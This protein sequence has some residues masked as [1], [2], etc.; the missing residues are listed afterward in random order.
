MS[1]CRLPSM[2]RLGPFSTS[3]GLSAGRRRA[4]LA[5]NSCLPVLESAGR[6]SMVTW[7]HKAG[8]AGLPQPLGV[9]KETVRQGIEGALFFGG[10]RLAKPALIG[11]CQRHDARMYGAAAR[12]QPERGAA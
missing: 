9:D 11:Q 6:Y 7:R 8:S 1:G 4:A 5:A 2:L 3:T 12:R 10:E